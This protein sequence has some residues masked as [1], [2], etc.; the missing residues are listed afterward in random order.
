MDTFMNK[1]LN[2]RIEFPNVLSLRP[3]TTDEVL[4]EDKEAMKKA[5]KARRK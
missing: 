1:K 4:K 3:Y 5:Q 2:S